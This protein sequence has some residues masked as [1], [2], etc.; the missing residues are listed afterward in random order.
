M[1]RIF[2]VQRKEETKNLVLVLA[3]KITVQC[4]LSIEE[5]KPQPLFL[6]DVFV[7]SEI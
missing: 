7:R 6:S 1:H 4:F 3:G 5:F 2:N